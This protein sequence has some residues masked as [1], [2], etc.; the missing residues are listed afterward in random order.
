[1]NMHREQKL[2]G[3]V[4]TLAMVLDGNGS[5]LASLTADSLADVNR[6]ADQAAR[7]KSAIGALDRLCEVRRNLPVSHFSGRICKGPF[8]HQH[9]I[10]IVIIFRNKVNFVLY[11]LLKDSAAVSTDRNSCSRTFVTVLHLC[12]LCVGW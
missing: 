2:K 10:Q 8:A 1:M 5:S 4:Q 6:L 3:E 7:C 9:L 11:T 12:A